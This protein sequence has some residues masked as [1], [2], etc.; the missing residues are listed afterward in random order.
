M[1]RPHS[2]EATWLRHVQTFVELH[3]EQGRALADLDR[4]VGVASMIWPHGRYRLDFTG[5]PDHAGTTRMEDRH[6]PML[7]YAMTALAA[8]KRAR[9]AGQRAT[10]GRISVE[11]NGTNAVPSLVTGWLDARAS[12]DDALAA[13]VEAVERHRRPGADPH[14]LNRLGRERLI[15][16]EVIADPARVGAARLAVA[17]P[18][19]P[20]VNI[21]DP[22]PCV[23]AGTDP[24]GRP[25]VVVCSSGV[26]LELVPYAADA[27]AA[28]DGARQGVD[29][30]GSRLVI[31][32]PSRDRL[33]VVDEIADHLRQPAAFVSS[34]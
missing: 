3:V 29:G 12:S 32:T 24:D 34:D 13:L 11:P 4:P 10:F 28:H 6:D 15:R 25:V 2:D 8:N 22:V 33:R 7:T 5:R 23:A 21:K 30:I 1:A 16:S 26:D 9:L 17:P 14:P 20:R 27:R 19:V 18:P 31:V